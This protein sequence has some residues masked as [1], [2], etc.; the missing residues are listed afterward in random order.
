MPDDVEE[1]SQIRVVHLLHTMDYGGVETVII[2]WLR[3]LHPGSV[4]ISIVCFANPGGTEQLFVEAAERAG[5]NV[6]TI[7]WSRRKPIL[8]SAKSLVKIL[9]EH[10]AEVIHTHNTY[11]D[12]VGLVAARRLGIRTVSSL[13][14]LSSFGWKRKTLERM[15]LFALR[16]FDCV[17]AQCEA[18]R[19]DICAGGINS[20]KVN[21][22][23]SGFEAAAPPLEESEREERRRKHGLEPHHVM[24]INVARLYPEKAHAS[25]LREFRKIN[26]AHPDTRLWILGRGPLEEEVKSLCTQLGLDDVVRFLGYV[27]DFDELICLADIQ[28]HPS[29]TEGIP[30]AILSGMASGLPVVASAVGGIEEVIENDV[31]G[32]LVPS[33]A[34]DGFS[35]AFYKAVTGLVEDVEERRRLGNAARRFIENDYSLENAALTLENIYRKLITA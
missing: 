4:D 23:H 1:V 28:L 10:R 8:K 22:L 27:P 12:L 2:N 18:T 34:D 7:P 17:T 9:R 5:F 20:E 15:T 35:E 21:V 25:L 33:A 6:E 11:A 24:M 19:R 32:L 13:Y 16:Y 31:R 30:M 26:D 3:T 29:F 14:V